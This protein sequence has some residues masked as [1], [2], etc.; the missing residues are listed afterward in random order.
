MLSRGMDERFGDVFCFLHEI[1]CLY[2]RSH[3]ILCLQLMAEPLFVA[4]L[5]A[6][7][8]FLLFDGSKDQCTAPHPLSVSLMATMKVI[9]TGCIATDQPYNFRTRDS[10]IT[11]FLVI[12]AVSFEFWNPESAVA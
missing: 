9:T 1:H 4:K 6:G 12:I 5:K 11:Y 7:F 10:S 3:I 2:D 8:V